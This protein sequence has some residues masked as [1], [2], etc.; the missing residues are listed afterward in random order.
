MVPGTFGWADIGSFLDLYHVVEQDDD[1]NYQEGTVKLKEAHNNYIYNAL[2]KPLLVIGLDNIVVVN[3]KDGILI[4]RRDRSPQ[5][6]PTIKE[7]WA[8]N[9]KK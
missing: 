5:V 9:K 7:Y 2:D 3:T 8:E 4:A 6:G 1:G